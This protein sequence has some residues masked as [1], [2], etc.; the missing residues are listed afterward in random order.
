M[1][2]LVGEW[3]E[4]EELD[5]LDFV[6]EWPIREDHVY[7]LKQWAAEGLLSPA[8]RARYDELLRLV[9]RNRP[10]LNDLLAE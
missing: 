3:E 7:Q 8:Q 4:W 5:R 10:I 6:L 2:D 1:P 9:E